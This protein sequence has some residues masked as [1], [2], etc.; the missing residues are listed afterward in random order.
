MRA[1]LIYPLLNASQK[2]GFDSHRS[3]DGHRFFVDHQIEYADEHLLDGFVRMAQAICD[4]PLEF[5]GWNLPISAAEHDWAREALAA[6]PPRRWR[7]GVNPAASKPV[8]NWPLDRTIALIDRIHQEFDA[9][10]VLTGGPAAEEKALAEQIVQTCQPPPLNLV[11]QTSPK[12][13]AALLG[14][15]DIFV[16]P[17]TGPTHIAAAMGTPVIGLYAVARPELS[18]PYV[19]R[20]W[21]I[22][23]YPRAVER[24]LQKPFEQAD[25]HERVSHPEAMS[26][27]QVDDVLEKLRQFC[28]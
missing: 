23:R 25:W 13:L 2:I 7:I 21:V 1:N 10:V 16:A 8:R 9:G 18:G 6:L 22:N 12:Q 14:Q 11:G 15:L 27:I 26:L 5:A 4:E 19:G 17:D 3:R 20:E 28:K 24:F